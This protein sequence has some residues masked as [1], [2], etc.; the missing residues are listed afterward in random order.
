MGFEIE[1]KNYPAVFCCD[2][3]CGRW[4]G[5]IPDFECCFPCGDTLEETVTVAEQMIV[6]SCED[7]LEYGEPIPEPTGMEEAKERFYAENPNASD[8]TFKMLNVEIKIPKKNID[9]TDF[10]TEEELCYNGI[11]QPAGAMSN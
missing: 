6:F 8:V 10:S 11:L 9:E 3:G 4:G 1:K 7:S 5:V 2:K